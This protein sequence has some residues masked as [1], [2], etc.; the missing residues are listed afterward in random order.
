MDDP[1]KVEILYPEDF[2]MRAARMFNALIAC[3]PQAGIEAIVTK[4]WEK[5]AEVLM[6]YG[7]GHPKRRLST[8]AH[9]K[10]GGRLIG[11]D[12]AYWDRENSMRC[13]VDHLHPWRLIKDMPPDR[14]SKSGINMRDDHDPDGP[15]VLVG[16]GRKSRAQ[17]AMQDRAWERQALK[18]IKAIYPG[19]QIIYKP[20]VPEDGLP[21][22]KTMNGPIEEALKG[23]FF[24]VCRHSNVA[25]DA[26]IAGVPVVCEDG[27]AKVLYGNDL[28]HPVSPSVAAREQF[29]QNLA[30][31]Q[32][33]PSEAVSAW[34]FL[35]SV[36]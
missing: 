24:V 13:T 1:M 35:R 31:W 22:C 18:G 16:M 32:W 21:G 5:K 33:M 3:A 17:F 6:S 10:A 8:E 14:F 28:S 25:V 23:A 30:Y 20:K 34:S 15:I 7:L 26:C 29:L 4:R 36:L 19:K 12:L 2:S 27:A 9:V 11:W